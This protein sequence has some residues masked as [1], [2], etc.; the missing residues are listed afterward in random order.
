M[1]GRL[2]DATGSY[3]LAFLVAAGSAVAATLIWTARA[4]RR[5]ESFAGA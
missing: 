3:Q 1:A 4:R 5:L 2:F